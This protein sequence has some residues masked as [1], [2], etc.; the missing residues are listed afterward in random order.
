MGSPNTLLNSLKRTDY[1]DGTPAGA[2]NIGKKTSAVNGAA[3]YPD[4]QFAVFRLISAGTETRTVSAPTKSGLQ[5]ALNGV[6]IAGPITITFASAYNEA[7]NTTITCTATGQIAT[8]ESVEQGADT[9]VWRLVKNDG[10]TGV[11]EAFPGA[12]TVAGTLTGSAGIIAKSA[13]AAA[14]ATTRTLTAADSGGCFSVAKTSAYAITLPTPA[15]GLRFKFMV[16]DTGANAVTISNGSAHLFGLVSVN[17]TN[18]AMTGTTLSLASA[19]SI[20]DWVEFE[21]IDA[22]HYLVTGA[23]IDAADITIA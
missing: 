13:T 1:T 17:N 15:Q 20:G 16:L 19:G 8:F 9:Y 5:F 21:G 23:C 22:T 11:T 18:T 7:G 3:L 2:P 12:V 4:R 14:I 6:T 10:M